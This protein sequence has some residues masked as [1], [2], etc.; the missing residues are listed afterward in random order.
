VEIKREIKREING[1]STGDEREINGRSTGDQMEIK[2][3]PLEI[4]R[5][6]RKRVSA[7]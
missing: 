7:T 4:K 3:G 6:E 5:G 1:R 2:T